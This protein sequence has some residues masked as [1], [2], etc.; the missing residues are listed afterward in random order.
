MS[1]RLGGNQAEFDFDIHARRRITLIGVTFRTRTKEEV[2]EIVAKMQADL[3]GALAA[4]KLRLPVSHSYP[5]A[6]LRQALAVMAENRHFG[7]IVLVL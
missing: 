2:R 1:G 5:F 4:G 6:D 3:D 7:K